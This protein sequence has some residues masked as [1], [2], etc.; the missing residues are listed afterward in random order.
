MNSEKLS[1]LNQLETEIIILDR[2]LFVI[3][4]ND[5]AL[6]KGWVL[7]S[8]KN[9]NLITDQFSEET[10]GWNFHPIFGVV[11]ISKKIYNDCTIPR[12]NSIPLPMCNI[13]SYVNKIE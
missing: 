13:F 2:D 1:F 7:N 3:W 11:D 5:S 12:K 4:L 8:K 10:N 9:H 6:N